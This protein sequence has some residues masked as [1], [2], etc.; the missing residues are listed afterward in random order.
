MDTYGKIVTKIVK[1]QTVIIGPIASEIAKRV[2][3]LRFA[4]TEVSFE[5]DPKETISSLVI[6]YKKI[7]GDASVE[8]CKESA[9]GIDVK[10]SD[11]DLPDILK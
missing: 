9:H 7:F 10:V 3:G 4:E 6:E 2:S 1:D 5:N 11:D 8:I